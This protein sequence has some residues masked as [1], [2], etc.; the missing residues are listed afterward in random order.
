MYTRVCSEPNSD[1]KTKLFKFENLYIGLLEDSPRCVSKMQAKYR[2]TVN[3]NVNS[4]E[5]RKIQPE[6]RTKL[7]RDIIEQNP[8]E[9][10]SQIKP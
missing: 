3:T 8:I 2:I 5:Q 1:V 4:Q 7:S 9:Q 6:I 10:M